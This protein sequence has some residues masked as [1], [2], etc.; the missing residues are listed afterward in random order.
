MNLQKI[1]VGKCPVCGSDVVKTIKGYACINSLEQEPSCNFFLFN[2][3]SNR[4]LSDNE[5]T[6]L[7]ANRSILL[8]GLVTKEGKAYSSIVSFNPDGSLDM[9]YT[10][11]KCPRC[12]GNANINARSVYCTNY[13]HPQSPCKFTIWRN[14]AGHPFSLAEL[15]ELLTKGETSRPVNTYDQHG[16]V[17][18]SR[19]ALNDNKE[20]TKVDTTTL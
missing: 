20:V 10:V 1:T 4:A 16:N 5:A 17:R 12:G 15:Q 13:S 7:L 6:E 18:Q 19:F 11:G 14:T 9:N 2:T 8:D 3:L